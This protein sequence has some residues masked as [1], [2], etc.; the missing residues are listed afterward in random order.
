MQCDLK[1]AEADLIADLGCGERVAEGIPARLEESWRF[2]DMEPRRIRM[3]HE[4][5]P[6]GFWLEDNT[7]DDWN[8]LAIYV[9]S[10]SAFFGLWGYIHIRVLDEGNDRQKLPGC[11]EDGDVHVLRE[12][13]EGIISTGMPGRLT[14]GKPLIDAELERR[15]AANE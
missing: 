2:T 4:R 13:D 3:S 8:S 15:I 6:D 5:I 10:N 7:L 11:T 9:G 14:K 1:E 12:Q